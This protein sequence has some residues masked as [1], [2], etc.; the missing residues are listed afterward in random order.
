MS[1]FQDVGGPNGLSEDERIKMIGNK[2][3]LGQKVAVLLE[4]DTLEKGKVDRY[5]RKLA[6][7]YPGVEITFRGPYTKVPGI[8][9]I[10][11]ERRKS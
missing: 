2:A 9:L 11:V 5:V 10:R 8:T 7:R 1:K 6:E 4:D 3:L